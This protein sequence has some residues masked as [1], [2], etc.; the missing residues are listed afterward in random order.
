MYLYTT[1]NTVFD[2]SVC[3]GAGSVPVQ[4]S[5]SSAAEAL[6]GQG[7]S[8]SRCLRQVSEG[9]LCLPALPPRHSGPLPLLA[10][11]RQQGAVAVNGEACI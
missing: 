9:A 7:P 8:A 3:V 11:V 5:V 1:C 6:E 2:Y 10:Q 4:P